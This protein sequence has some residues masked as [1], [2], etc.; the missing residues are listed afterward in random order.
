MG[1]FTFNLTIKLLLV[2]VYVCVILQEHQEDFTNKKV[3]LL[4]APT[5]FEP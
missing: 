5:Y 2:C 3:N 4:P 1:N